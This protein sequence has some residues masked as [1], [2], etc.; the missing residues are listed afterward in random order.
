MTYKKIIEL[1]TGIITEISD[2]L[3]GTVNVIYK[4]L[5]VFNK[6]IEPLEKPKGY[7]IEHY[8]DLHITD[9]KKWLEYKKSIEFNKPIKS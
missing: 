9:Q 5:E 8:A 3:E 6:P 2:R 7:G 1:P 4:I